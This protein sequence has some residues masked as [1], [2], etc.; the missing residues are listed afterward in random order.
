MTFAQPY[1]L[2]LLLLLPVL[3]WYYRLSV[4]KRHVSLQVSRQAAMRGVKTWV[5]YARSWIQ[6]FRWITIGLLITAMARPQ[7]KWVEEK[8]QTEA[9]DIV[10]AI[11]VSPSMLSRDI[12]PDRFTIAKRVAADFVQNRPYDRLGL[13]IFSGGAFTQCPLTNDRQ[14]LKAFISNLQVGRLPDGSA[15]GMGLATAINRLKDSHA[16]SKVVILLTDGENN[17]GDL[18]PFTAA[19]IAQSLGVRVYTVGLGTD[20][21]VESPAYRR[22]TGTYVFVTRKMTLNT[23][24]LEGIAGLT[25]GKFYRAQS[26]SD[27]KGIYAEID[28]LEKTKVEVSVVRNTTELFFWFLAA[29]F[30]I[31]VLEMLLR[32]GPLRVI[33]V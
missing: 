22:P 1:W 24:M 33:T 28:G 9:I 10:L 3:V 23:D 2:L 7:A 17:E 4:R 6:V 32:W 26:A 16:K 19:Q 15:V 14:I 13:V 29:A 12:L 30:S 20:G 31:L 5:V 25:G 11:D 18:T 21:L 27:L 8:T